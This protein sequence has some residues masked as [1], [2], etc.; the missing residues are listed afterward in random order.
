VDSWVFSSNAREYRYL[1]RIAH[2]NRGTAGMYFHFSGSFECRFSNRDV[3]NQPHPPLTYM[4]WH[5]DIVALGMAMFGI[6]FSLL[7][8]IG[9]RVIRLAEKKTQYEA[10]KFRLSLEEQIALLSKQI[11]YSANR[12]EGVNHLLLDSQKA[13]VGRTTPSAGSEIFLRE[14]GVDI[15]TKADDT[16]VFV[17]IPFHPDFEKSYQVITRTVTDLGLNCSRGDDVHVSSNILSHIVQEI[18]RARLIIADITS[19]NPNVYYELGIA[20]AIGKPVLLIAQ[21]ANELP[22]DISSRRVLVYH[23]LDDLEDHLRK[24]LTQTLAQRR[25]KAP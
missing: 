8:V 1:G 6:I 16:L 7:L 10:D 17:L 2:G 20:Q 4:N 14:M 18:Y 15:N 3:G 23:T 11:T 9:L 5:F 19:R 12:F 13:A 24:W 22:F 21:N 25:E